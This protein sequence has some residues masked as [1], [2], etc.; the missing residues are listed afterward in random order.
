MIREILL[1]RTDAGVAA[2]V[3]ALAV[4]VTVGVVV[5]R[6]SREGLLVVIGAG[7]LTLGF[8]GLRMLH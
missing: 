2:Q 4:V 8:F 6:R 5:L 1:P 3:V 7:A